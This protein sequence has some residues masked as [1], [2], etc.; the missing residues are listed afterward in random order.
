MI[1]TDE[2][3]SGPKINEKLPYKQPQP[4]P[5]HSK[6]PVLSFLAGTKVA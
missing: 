5:G 1:K 2:I 6:I 3:E 4:H